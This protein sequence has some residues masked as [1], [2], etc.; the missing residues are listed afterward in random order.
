[1]DAPKI[2]LI[3]GAVLVS[4]SAIVCSGLE[5][6]KRYKRQACRAEDQSTLL[7]E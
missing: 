2:A 6:H 5:G 7:H 4:I 3:V 1:M